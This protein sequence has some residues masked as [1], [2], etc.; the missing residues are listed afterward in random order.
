[1]FPNA[2]IVADRFHISQHI[3]RAFTNHRIQVMKTFK[4]GSSVEALKEIL[5]TTSKNAWELNGQH[6]YWRPSFRDHLTE[7]EIVDRLLYYDDS[8]K[9]GYEVY[10]VFL[11]AIRRQDVPEFV[12]LLKEDYKELPEHYQPVF[13]TFKKYRTEIKRALR[14]PYSNGPIECLN[15]HIKVLKR[16]AYGFRNFQNYR[17]RIFYIEENI[18]R[19]LRTLPN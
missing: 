1:M 12:A 18:S 2:R 14:V 3:G 5:E 4:R 6:R 9:R 16:I 8:L 11:S 13:T 17:E 19:K 15:N 10:Q 7:A